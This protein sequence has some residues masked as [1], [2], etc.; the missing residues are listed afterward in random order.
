MEITDLLVFTQKNKASDLHLSASNPPVLRIHGQMTPYKTNPL[1]VEDVKQML[2]SIM[3]EQQ[4][5]DYE[6]DFELDFAI[7][8]GENM[9]FRVNAFNTLNG[10]AAVLR[11]IPDRILSLEELGAPDILKKLCALHKGLILVTGPTGSGKS[12]TL[13]AM[14]NHINANDAK[15]IITIEDPVE[16]IHQSKK[17]LINQREVGKNTKSFAKALRSALRE[18]PDVILVGE[19]RDMET[20]QLALT[21]AETGHLVMGTLH[22]NSAPKTIDRI[23]DVFPAN[24]KEM[25]RA[26]L[27]VSLEAVITQTLLKRKDDGRVAAHEIMLG[28]PAVRNLIREGKI[29]QLYSMLQ[30][31]SKVG[32]C[33]MKDSVFALYDQGIIT[34]QTAKSALA[35]STTDDS[36]EGSPFAGGSVKSHH[37]QTGGGQTTANNNTRKPT[38]A[39]NVKPAHN[40]F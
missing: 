20:I 22:T 26:M 16:F 5:S 2:Y 36:E 15:H 7:S 11:T 32:M 4:R 6:R 8:F 3:T 13:A 14:V 24:D 31:G 33:L 1:T 10:P 21:A 23:I 34:E 17:S 30:I 37:P 27:S 9:R 12:T 18:D 29:P 39:A 28:T 19:L 35:S 25:I 40:G 38:A